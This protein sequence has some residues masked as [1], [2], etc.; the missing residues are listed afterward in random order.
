[1]WAILVLAVLL[2]A[3]AL[4][5]GFV[6]GFDVG[7]HDGVRKSIA[8]LTKE[9]VTR[10]PCPSWLNWFLDNVLRPKEIEIDA[11]AS[12]VVDTAPTAH[13]L[14]LVELDDEHPAA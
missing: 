6:I 14:R 7:Q 4:G 12:D 13:E 9:P 1:M 11:D 5:L 8:F 2:A 10:R 3:L